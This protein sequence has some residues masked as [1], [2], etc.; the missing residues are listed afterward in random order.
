[1]IIWLLRLQEELEGTVGV[2]NVSFSARKPTSG[3]KEEFFSADYIKERIFLNR[4][5]LSKLS[6]VEVR[7]LTFCEKQEF[8]AKLTF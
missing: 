3:G 7:N 1:M 6:T 4:I 5:T 2:V 8:E